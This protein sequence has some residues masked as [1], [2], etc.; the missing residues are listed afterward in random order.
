[1]LLGRTSDT[2]SLARNRGQ[3]H[4]STIYPDQFEEVR[5][6]TAGKGK[7]WLVFLVSYGGASVRY[8]AIPGSELAWA[9]L[10]KRGDGSAFI[11]V[12]EADGRLSLAQTD[13]MLD[14]SVYAAA[15]PTPA[16]PRTVDAVAAIPTFD[17]QAR[18]SIDPARRSGK[19]CIR[20]TRMTVYDI[21]EYLA[22]GMSQA[23]VLD[24]F[25]D[26]E[27]DDIRAALAFAVAMGRRVRS[28]P[29]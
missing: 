9:A 19:P 16:V 15:I 4:L 27:P 26:L 23:E 24:D 10:P 6:W 2:R 14:V 20:G 25:P 13:G 1:M 22:S 7:T 18:I 12:Y 21:L 8:V 17:W 3:V 28:V 5:A 11:K 29:A